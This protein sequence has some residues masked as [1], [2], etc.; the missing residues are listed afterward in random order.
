MGHVASEAV[1]GGPIAF[2]TGGDRIRLD[3]ATGTHDVLVNDDELV[4]RAV[5]WAPLP[6]KFIKGVL[7]KYIKLVHSASGGAI[8]E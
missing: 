4:R 6:P 2:V 5:G 7:G 1:D 8:L 3:V